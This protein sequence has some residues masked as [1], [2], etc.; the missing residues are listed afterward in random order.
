MGMVQEESSYIPRATTKM[1]PDDF[2]KLLKLNNEHPWLHSESEALIELWNL[3]DEEQQQ[4]LI[5]ELIRRFKLIDSSTLKESGEAVTLHVVEHWGLEAS[6]TRIV[7]VSD[8]SEADGSQAFLQSMKNKFSAHDGWAEKCFVNSI[9]DG[10]DAAKPNYTVILVDDFIGSGSTIKRRVD[11][12]KNEL[13]TKNI[14][15]VTLKVVAIAGME[16][17][18]Q[19]LDGLGVEYYCPFW[20]KRGI[21]DYKASAKVPNPVEAM[22]KLE[23]KLANRYRG[24]FLPRFGYKRTEA[25]FCVEAYNVPNNVFPV[26]WWPVLKDYEPRKTLFRRLR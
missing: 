4:D 12:V 5:V 8:K 10:V 17:A 25:L 1:N 15:N 19:V 21:S 6:T 20:L 7:A 16:A 13:N 24:Q 18:K 14:Q 22:K 11:W 3:C 23:V 9:R 26:F 2:H